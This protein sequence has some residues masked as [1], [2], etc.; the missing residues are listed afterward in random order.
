MEFLSPARQLEIVSRIDVFMISATRN[1]QFVFKELVCLIIFVKDTFG[2]DLN[3][4]YCL[5][6][7]L[8]LLMIRFSM[9]YHPN[10]CSFY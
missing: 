5:F 6:I 8:S 4:I 3:N 2:T 1:I 9:K 7:T 10:I